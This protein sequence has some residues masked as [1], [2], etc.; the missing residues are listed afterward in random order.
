[1]SLKNN[2]KKGLADNIRKQLAEQN[3][4]LAKLNKEFKFYKTLDDVLIET[5]S[6]T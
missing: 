1:L 4:D 5:I 6:R 3:P 2:I